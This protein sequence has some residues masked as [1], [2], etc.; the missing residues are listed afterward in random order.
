MRFTHSSNFSTIHF[1]ASKWSAFVDAASDSRNEVNAVAI[2]LS[3]DYMPA[4]RSLSD[5]F[6]LQSACLFVRKKNS[7]RDT[8]GITA[9]AGNLHTTS[10]YRQIALALSSFVLARSN[11]SSATRTASAAVRSPVPSGRCWPM[12]VLPSFHQAK[13][14]M[15]NLMPSRTPLSKSACVFFMSVS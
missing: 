6:A 7:K 5:W 3:R 1:L 14:L 11:S 9:V 2:V 15:P 13:R 4:F 8:A 10:R 12:Y